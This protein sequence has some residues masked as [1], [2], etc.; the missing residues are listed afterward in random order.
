LSKN[1]RKPQAAGGWIFLT[2]TVHCAQYP[3]NSKMAVT[4]MNPEPPN[5][6]IFDDIWADN[7]YNKMSHYQYKVKY[8]RRQ[9]FASFSHQHSL[10][11]RKVTILKLPTNSSKDVH[12]ICWL[13]HL[14][15]DPTLCS[16]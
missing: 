5:L 10:Q 13:E 3:C 14:T 16:M 7:H 6:G 4:N 2:H 11:N 9:Q 1:V 15:L 12:V 8:S